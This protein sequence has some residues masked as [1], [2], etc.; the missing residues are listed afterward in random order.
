TTGAV[1]WIQAIF[2]AKSE[3]E[4]NALE[5]SYLIAA[6]GI[7]GLLGAFSADKLRARLGL[8]VVLIGSIVLESLGFIFPLIINNVWGMAAAFLWISAVGLYSSICI[9]SYRQEAFEEKYLGRI[10]GITGSLFKLLMPF[11]LA[12]S[13][14]LIAHFGIEAIFIS[15]FVVQLFAALGLLCSQVRRIA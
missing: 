11:G 13:G 8:G 4:F 9:W 2:Y 7:G 1:F 10:A 15:C 3:L 5:V 12:A 6:S 14:Y